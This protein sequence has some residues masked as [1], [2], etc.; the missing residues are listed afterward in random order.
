ML[1]DLGVRLDGPAM[2]R[3]TDVRRGRDE[4]MVSARRRGDR[5]TLLEIEVLPG[6]HWSHG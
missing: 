4:V 3:V 2:Y 6:T 1:D 5:A